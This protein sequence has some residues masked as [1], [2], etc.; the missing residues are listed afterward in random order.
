MSTNQLLINRVLDRT[1]AKDVALVV[2]GVAMLVATAQLQ[3]P[4]Y[5]VPLTMQTLAVLLLAAGLGPV[6]S[7]ASVLGYLSLGA[8]GLPVFAGFKN[9]LMATTTWGYLIGFL[10]AAIVVGAIGSRWQLSNWYRVA[11]AF[12]LGSAVIYL[13][14][15]AGL[16]LSL[17]IDA[18]AAFSAGV[19]PFLLGDLVKATIAAALLPVAW[20]LAK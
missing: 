15:M 5:P 17:G 13:F 7:A 6:R 4:F 2:S 19:A 16:M 18:I 20:R 11:V 12:A 9:L 8:A 3:I 14:G 10:V 1:I